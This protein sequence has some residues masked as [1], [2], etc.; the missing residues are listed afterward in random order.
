MIG[1]YGIEYPVPLEFYA[2]LDSIKFKPAT[3]DTIWWSALTE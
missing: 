1:N 2:E 3:S